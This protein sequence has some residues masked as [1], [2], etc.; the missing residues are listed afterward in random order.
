MYNNIARSISLLDKICNFCLYRQ[1]FIQVRAFELVDP[2]SHSHSVLKS[3]YFQVQY[4]YI[5]VFTTTDS[6]HKLLTM[7]VLSELSCTVGC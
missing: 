2:L 3:I 4:N 1:M 5:Y 7:Q 6:V